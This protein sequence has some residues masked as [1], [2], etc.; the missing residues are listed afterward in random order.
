MLPEP[1]TGNAGTSNLGF[2]TPQEFRCLK[3]THTHAGS[4]DF[5]VTG[6]Y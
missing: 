4:Q 6:I 5:R 1:T 3:S 2:G